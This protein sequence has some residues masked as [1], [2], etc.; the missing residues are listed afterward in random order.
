MSEIILVLTYALASGWFARMNGGAPPVLPEAVDRLLALSAIIIFSFHIGPVEGIVSL[1][2][3]PLIGAGPGQYFLKM[4][5]KFITAERVDPLLRPFFGLDPRTIGVTE[6]NLKEWR[7][8]RDRMTRLADLVLA[9]G[10]RR[11]WVRNVCGLALVGLAP[12]LPVVVASLFHMK[13]TSAALIALAGLWMGPAYVIGQQIAKTSW[14]QSIMYLSED[15]AWGEFLRGFGFCI[16]VYGAYL[17][18]Q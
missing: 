1:L 18:W 2:G 12:V 13:L 4:N 17:A 6:G 11:L 9:Y 7:N 16:L 5:I 10:K 3:I 14:G 15:T 8:D